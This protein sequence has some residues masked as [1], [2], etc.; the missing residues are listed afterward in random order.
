MPK[1]SRTSTFRTG[2]HAGSRRGRRRASVRDW[3]PDQPGAWAMALLPA[4][5]GV[6]IGGVTA[7]TLWLLAAW[8]LCYCVQFTAARWLK[9]RFSRRYLPQVLIYMASLAAVGI[10]FLAV[11]PG[12]LRWAPYFAVLAAVS[13]A[14]AYLRR[15]RSLWGNGAAVLASSSMPTVIASFG[16]PSRLSDGCA[17]PTAIANGLIS[18][19]DCV[20]Y[21]EHGAALFRG[22]LPT[23]DTWWSTYA[24]PS[25]G[26]VTS[27]LFA[28]T[29]FGSVLFVKTMIRERG[30]RRYLRASWGWHGMLL[31]LCAAAW[32]F[33]DPS[34]RLAWLRGGW[35]DP[36]S[37]DWRGC[38]TT[39]VA[40]CLLLRAIVLP[41]IARNRVL[42][43]IAVG[44]T[45]LTSSLL[46]FAT[47]VAF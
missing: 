10:P 33:S 46:V 23:W 15:E 21:V 41:I 26:L 11:N 34:G 14:A 6:A 44:M 37:F 30:N 28:L 12:V 13:F 8:T 43:P 47:S 40:A 39:I 3:I 29:Q 31:A 7:N 25:A 42:K 36:S 9:S 24:L 27:L 4:I 16:D 45:E 18:H 38:M 19:A 5:S 17:V 20:R 2:A 1:T 32:L 22:Q 35:S